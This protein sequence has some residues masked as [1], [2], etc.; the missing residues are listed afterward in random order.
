MTDARDAVVNEVPNGAW[1]KTSQAGCD[2]PEPAKAMADV[3]R[4]VGAGEQTPVVG[5][6]DDAVGQRG[7]LGLV[8]GGT[9]GLALE[10]GKSK[11]ASIRIVLQHEDYGPVA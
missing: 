2:S 5:F 9:E 1:N 11:A 8:D 6:H 4:R 10:W 7:A 3:K